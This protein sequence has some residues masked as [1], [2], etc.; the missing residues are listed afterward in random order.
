MKTDSTFWSQLSAEVD[1]YKK[2]A[3]VNLQK[4]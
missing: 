2:R 1:S 3:K 4:Y